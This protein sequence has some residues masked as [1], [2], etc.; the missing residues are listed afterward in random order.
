MWHYSHCLNF[1]PVLIQ[2]SV[3]QSFQILS[4]SKCWGTFSVPL[5][6]LP[7]YPL[8]LPQVGTSSLFNLFVYSNFKWI[9]NTWSQVSRRCCLRPHATVPIKQVVLCPSA[10]PA[11]FPGI[12]LL[13]PQQP[14]SKGA[15]DAGTNYLLL[16]INAASLESLELQRFEPGENLAMELYQGQHRYFQGGSPGTESGFGSWVQC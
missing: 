9:S 7:G 12:A 5:W 8:E 3:F 16:G 4:Y 13:L 11:P 6:L 2:K 15:E 14:G 1:F 10:F